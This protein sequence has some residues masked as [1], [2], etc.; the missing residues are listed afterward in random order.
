VKKLTILLASVAIFTS[1]TFAQ[2]VVSSAVNAAS[3]ALPEL[4]SSG[5]AQ[6]SM[7][8]VFGQR[9]GPATL[10]IINNFPLPVQLEGTSIKV[11]A[12]GTTVDAYMIYTSAGQL[13][14]ILPSGTPVGNGSLTVTY[15]G[16][17]SAALQIRVVAA[18]FGTFSVN[19]AGSGPGIVQNVNSEVDRPIN[20]LNKPARPGQV[21]ILW[22]TG[23]GPTT[24]N[25]RAGVVPGDLP[26]NVELLVGGKP[27]SI[28]YKGRSG[29]C[30]GIDQ[31]VFTVPEGVE[32]CYVPVV[33]KIGNSISNFTTMSIGRGNAC[34][35]PNGVSGDELLAAQAKGTFSSG[36]IGLTRTALKISVSGF[37]LDSKTDSGFGS[38]I[39]FNFDRLV[40]SQGVGGS[41]AV[42][43]GA[44]TVYAYRGTSP[45]GPVDPIRPEILDAGPQITIVG[46]K[47]T[48]QLVK[49]AA[50]GGTYTAELGGG[51][52]GLPIPIPGQTGTP[53]YLDPGSYTISGP[54]GQH[55]GAFTV[56]LTVPQAL[57]WDNL[58]A[59]NTVNRSLGQEITWSGGD[60]S[61]YT[62]ITGFSF[63]NN[64]VGGFSCLERTSARR[65]TIPSY[66]LL[67]LP[68]S[69]GQVPGNIS[70]S[71]SGAIAR[72]TASGLDSGIVSASASSSKTVT[73]Q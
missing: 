47:G 49:S 66:V 59:V 21:M 53:E 31:I 65:F 51:T 33:V 1:A 17:T 40:Q 71:G 45:G 10:S 57:T 23:L 11:T 58:E 8:I 4:P 19:Q 16:Q 6:G 28:S 50:S 61:G 13:A 34:S 9:M 29:C 60:P 18:A 22:G 5:I 68:P 67:N 70:V 2:P 20:A 24:A 46:P 39:R 73:F 54:G 69:S 48:K 41:S 44:C 35:D 25:E 55:V 32:G 43:L 72:F 63:S 15:N 27:A 62:I 3:Y 42:S 36:V 30:A 52:T 26:V 14:A 56:N 64:V 37:T 7:F 12:G 38:F